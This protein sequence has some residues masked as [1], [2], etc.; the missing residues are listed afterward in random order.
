MTVRC[1]RALWVA[2]VWG[3]FCAN[4][5]AQ[6]GPPVNGAELFATHCARC[7]GLTGDGNGPENVNLDRPARSFAAGGFSFGDTHEAIRRTLEMGIPG[8]PMPAFGE[9]LTLAER[10]ALAEHVR[11][12]IPE[13]RRVSSDETELVVGSL[14]VMA[15]GH[16]A[17]LSD[18]ARAHSRGLV[19]GTPHGLSFVLRADDLRLLGVTQGRF[20]RRTDWTGR[21]GTPLELL[22]HTLWLDEGGDPATRWF[23]RT[24]SGEAPLRVQLQSTELRAGGALLGARLLDNEG[25]EHGTL[26]LDLGQLRD[27]FTFGFRQSWTVRSVPGSE[28]VLE[29]RAPRGSRGTSFQARTAGVSAGPCHGPELLFAA[30]PTQLADR[31]TMQAWRWTPSAHG[32]LDSTRESEGLLRFH[33]GV[34]PREPT[35]APVGAQ[36]LHEEVGLLGKLVPVDEESFMRYLHDPGWGS[37]AAPVKPATE[38]AR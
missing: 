27:P 24:D 7:H 14:G 23:V 28:L 9:T 37:P 22:G 21:G 26:Q 20:V 33:F 17:P 12:L 4:L 6:D 29:W 8:S 36:T 31:G 15:R 25:R 32:Q 16:L 38:G 5:S 11:T 2:L 35:C 1:D 18:G 10:N 30:R 19:I 13:R 34:P 3:A